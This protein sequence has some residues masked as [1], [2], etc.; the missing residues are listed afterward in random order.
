ME[1]KW[2]FEKA[3]HI[4]IV[5]LFQYEHRDLIRITQEYGFDTE[6]LLFRKKRGWL[7]VDLGLSSNNFEFHRKKITRLVDNHFKDHYEYRVKLSGEIISL[8]SWLEV[9]ELYT[10]W[11]SRLAS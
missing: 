7:K 6:E 1:I 2:K 11:I 4:S 9:K 3:N 5:R 10:D 8:Q